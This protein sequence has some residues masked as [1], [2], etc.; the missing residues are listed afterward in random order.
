VRTSDFVRPD[1]HYCVGRL[2]KRL[3]RDH[4]HKPI[5]VKE[6]ALCLPKRV[7][8]TIKWREGAAER[9]SSRFA[10]A[11]VCVAHQ[12]YQLTESRPEEWLLIEWPEGEDEPTKY[13]LS[14]TFNVTAK[15]HFR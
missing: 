8:R 11:R 4:K 15:D 5:S 13:G 2:P 1:Y 7:W 10:R 9:L 3:R 6:L 12:D 14:T